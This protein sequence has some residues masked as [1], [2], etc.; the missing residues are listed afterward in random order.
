MTMYSVWQ[1]GNSYYLDGYSNV[2][3]N[4]L[5]DTGYRIIIKHSHPNPNP[6]PKLHTI[7]I[8]QYLTLNPFSTSCGR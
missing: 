5:A 1:Q 8:Y 7:K 2:A 6:N 3:N 4:M